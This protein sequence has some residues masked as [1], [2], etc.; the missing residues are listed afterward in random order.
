MRYSRIIEFLVDDSI[1]ALLGGFDVQD[2]LAGKDSGGDLVRETLVR[3]V[4]DPRFKGT[5]Q[6]EKTWEDHARKSLEKFAQELM[7]AG[8]LDAATAD[9]L[10]E[11]FLTKFFLSAVAIAVRK[12]PRKSGKGGSGDKKGEGGGLDM[13]L[14][15]MGQGNGEE[16]EKAAL[17][18]EVD[19]R[20][21]GEGCAGT[22]AEERSFEKMFLRKMPPSLKELARRI[23]RAGGEDAG[24]AVRFMTAAKSDIAGITVGNDLSSLLPSEVALLAEPRTEDIFLRGYAEKRLQVFASASSGSAEPVDRRD[25]PVVVCLDMSGSMAGEPADVAR[26]LT[27]AVTIIAR[28]RHREVAVVKYGNDEHDC[29]FVRNLRKDRKGLV[30]FLAFQSMGGN[31]EDMMFRWLFR[32]VLPGERDFRSAD[33]LCVSDFWWSPIREDAMDA[34]REN[35][36]KGMKFYGLRVSQF[37]EEEWDDDR[38]T[39]AHSVIDEMW[40]WDGEGERCV[41]VTGL[42]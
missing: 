33:V 2:A 19:G 16:G 36:A 27:M 6:A 14:R 20:G 3:A 41:Q 4:C 1:A 35:K 18:E 9:F 39:T 8:D 11:R 22:R 21:V 10:L 31:N 24:K 30:D 23:G 40:N 34:I 7:D 29:F 37:W 25:G 38:L 5:V 32:E 42:G 12:K 15:M 17:N 26:V 13:E 28:R